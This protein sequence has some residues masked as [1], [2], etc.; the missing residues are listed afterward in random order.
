MMLILKE[1]N[2]L[3]LIR[4]FKYHK[5][6]VLE[7]TQDRLKRASGL[8]KA[9]VMDSLAGSDAVLVIQSI[10]DVRKIRARV[11]AVGNERVMLERGVS[12][13]LSSILDIEFP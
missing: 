3:Q 11:I 13:P 10:G 12:I 4:Q 7:T 5:W 6:D 8:M 9:A 1:D 2:H